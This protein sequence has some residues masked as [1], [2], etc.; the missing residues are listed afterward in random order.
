MSSQLATS[1]GTPVD[2]ASARPPWLFPAFLFVLALSVLKGLRMPN[3]WAVTHYLF[4]YQTGFMKRALWGELLRLLLGS[5]TS[6]YFCLAGIGLAVLSAIL[7]LLVREC[8]HLPVSADGIAFLFVFA[9]SPAIAFAAHLVG[10]LEQLGYLALLIV[11]A[12]GRWPRV[13]IAAA[14]GAG[15]VLPL[16][17]E[18]SVFWVAPLFALTVLAGSIERP[19]P[20]V[21]R[22]LVIALLVCAWVAG[23]AAVLAFGQV[24]P[25]RANR[26]RDE[27]TAFF[28]IRPRQDAF[29]ALSTSTTASIRTMRTYWADGNVRRDMAYSVAVFGPAAAFLGLIA[30]RRARRLD[31]PR[32]VRVAA[33]ALALAAIAGPLALHVVAWDRHRWNALATLNAGIAALILLRITRVT[34]APSAGTRAGSA[35]PIALAIAVAAWSLSSDP[36]LFDAYGPAHPPFVQQI[37]FLIDAV[38]APNRNLWIPGP[39]K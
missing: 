31:A 11:V 32:S 13:Q 15:F 34:P 18:A 27:R 38:R 19:R 3:R 4:N 37:S 28:E 5:R 29:S 33:V 22:V 12:L 17:H 20:H 10:Y 36:M 16:V 39:G 25:E 7:V 26:I 23:T 21:S 35:A 30:V 8:R 24:S 9:A 14:V 1:P 2:A 6:N